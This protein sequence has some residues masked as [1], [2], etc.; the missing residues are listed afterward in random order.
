MAC[1]SPEWV[2]QPLAEAA[3]ESE[4]GGNVARGFLD[5]LLG[6]SEPSPELTDALAE[7]AR[8]GQERPSLASP[9]AL[10]TDLLPILAVSEDVNPPNLSHEQATAKLAGRDS[11]APRGNGSLRR[12]KPA[13]SLGEDRGDPAPTGAEGQHGRSCG[14]GSIRPI[15]GCRIG[16]GDPFRPAGRGNDRG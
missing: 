8:L 14:R 9:I 16:A 4:G 13:F 15:V 7:L 10:L 3:T 6:R 2:A 11:L 5:K 1:A 12:Q